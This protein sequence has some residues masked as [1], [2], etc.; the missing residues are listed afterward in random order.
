MR[1]KAR[2]LA[3][4][5][6]ETSCPRSCA[7]GAAVGYWRAGVVGVDPQPNYPF[8]QADALDLDSAFLSRFAEC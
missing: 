1:R 2:A 7:G 5:C 3:S 6:V 4:R 8:D